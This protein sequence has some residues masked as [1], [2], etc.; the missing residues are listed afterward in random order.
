[1]RI[2]PLLVLM[3][4]SKSIFCQSGDIENKSEEKLLKDSTTITSYKKYDSSAGSVQVIDTNSKTPPLNI[5][6][7]YMVAHQQ[8]NK[9][10]QNKSAILRIVIGA[11]LLLVL[12]VRLRKKSEK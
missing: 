4:L 3:L 5:D 11:G 1:M 10:R 8:E 2:I 9:A 6:V 12:I 7:N